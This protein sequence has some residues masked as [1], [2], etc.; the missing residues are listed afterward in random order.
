MTLFVDQAGEDFLIGTTEIL[1]SEGDFIQRF[2][3]AWFMAFLFPS[4]RGIEGDGFGTR[5]G[6]VED[7]LW[8]G[9]LEERGVEVVKC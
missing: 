7:D 2:P 3:I 5:A 9:V 1:W 4:T 8:E 6:K